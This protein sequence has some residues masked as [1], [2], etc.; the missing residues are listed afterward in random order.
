MIKSDL[1]IRKSIFL[2]KASDKTKMTA[3]TYLRNPR[4][5]G[6]MTS[7]MIE[8]LMK[9]IP[10]KI[11]TRMI[12]A[13]PLILFKAI[14]PPCYCCFKSEIR[15]LNAIKLSIES[16]SARTVGENP[17]SVMSPNQNSRS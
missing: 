1:V 3:N 17:N 10:Q 14:P 7:K 13:K 8:M 16:A 15:S 9:E 5:T 2:I 12:D 11:T 6:W 4:I